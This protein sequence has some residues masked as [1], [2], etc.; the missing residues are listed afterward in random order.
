MAYFKLS[1]L[2][3]V[4]DLYN[5]NK[6]IKNVISEFYGNNKKEE[7]LKYENSSHSD[8]FVNETINMTDVYTKAYSYNEKL[9]LHQQG[10]KDLTF[11]LD[12]N[13]LDDDVWKEN[14]F[15]SKIKCGSQLL[16]E[17]KYNN[18]MLFT[19]K[20]VGY[21]ITE[22]NLTYSFTCQDSFSFTLSKQNDGYSISNDINSQNFIGA[23]NIDSWTNKIIE[24]CKISY[25]YI[26]LATPL[27]LFTDGTATTFLSDN[28]QVSKILKTGYVKNTENADLYETIPFSCSSTSAKG[29]LVSLG[30]QLGLSINTATILKNKEEGNF[31]ELVT[32][33]WYEMSKKDTVSGLKYSP[34]RN[35][36]SFN[37]SQNSDSLLT[38]LNINSR[39]LSSGEEVTPLS[40]VSPA[41]VTL[42]NSEYWKKFSIYQTGMYT[43]LLTG[44]YF[45]ANLDNYILKKV[46]GQPDD[47]EDDEI[48][49]NLSSS[50]FY[51]NITEEEFK[52]YSLYDKTIFEKD[53]ITCG[54]SAII[55]GE[56]RVFDATNTTIVQGFSQVNNQYLIKFQF[57]SIPHIV[58]IDLITNLQLYVY[59]QKD[60]TD[61]DEAFAKIADQ[62]PYL[63]N[64]L[65]DFNYFTKNNLISKTQDK[66]I[67]NI[68]YNDLRKV[69]SEIL[70][71]ANIYYNRIHKQ[72]E[73]LATMTNGIDNVGAELSRITDIYKE[74]GKVDNYDV[75]NIYTRWNL[76]QYNVSGAAQ[77]SQTDISGSYLTSG[78]ID[79]YKTTSDYMRKFLNARQRCLKNLYNFKNYFEEKLDDRYTHLYRVQIV[80]QD[81]NNPVNLYRFDATNTDTYNVLS[82][83][84][85]N[86]YKNFFSWENDKAAD[87]HNLL[88]YN[89]DNQHTIFDKDNYLITKTNYNNIRFHI[90]EDILK[91]ESYYSKYD[92]NIKYLREVCF[93]RAKTILELFNISAN[94][95]I[96]SFNLKISTNSG[97]TVNCKISLYDKDYNY[98]ICNKIFEDGQS[99]SHLYLLNG[100]TIV[101]EGI[102]YSSPEQEIENLIYVNKVLTNTDRELIQQDTINFVK[103]DTYGGLVF[104]QEINQYDI[105]KNYLWRNK[106]DLALYIKKDFTYK[107]LTELL[108]GNTVES[109][110]FY[111][112]KYPY[113]N[114]SNAHVGWGKYFNVEIYRM[115]KSLRNDDMIPT[116]MMVQQG[117]L[118]G[119]TAIL[120]FGSYSSTASKLNVDFDDDYNLFYS[121]EAKRN[122]LYI[123]NY[124]LNEYFIETGSEYKKHLIPTNTSYQN[125]Y[126]ITRNNDD[127]KVSSLANN[128][129]YCSLD[130]DGSIDGTGTGIVIARYFNHLFNGFVSEFPKS[131]FYSTEPIYSITGEDND[132]IAYTFGNLVNI[133]NT[134]P[135]SLASA[136]YKKTITYNQVVWGND[137]FNNHSNLNFLVI[138]KDRFL[139]DS[140][141]QIPSELNQYIYYDII[142]KSE[143]LTGREI[144]EKFWSK[145]DSIDDEYAFYLIINGHIQLID[146][147]ITEEEFYNAIIVDEYG[148]KQ[149]ASSLYD[150]TTDAVT[151]L[152]HVE[153]HVEIN[154]KS[155]NYNLYDHLLDN[156]YELYNDRGEK[157]YTINQLFGNLLYKEP[158]TYIYY[159]FDKTIPQDVRLHRYNDQSTTP[160]IIWYS[161]D[162]SGIEGSE[163]IQQY[164]YAPYS[165]FSYTVQVTEVE[166]GIDALE[167]TNGTFWYYFTLN[168]NIDLGE[169]KLIP[170]EYAAM[171]EST[172]QEYWNEAYASSLLCDIFIPEEWRIKQ[173]QVK[174]NFDVILYYV[175]DGGFNVELNTLYVPI[176]SKIKDKSY[177][178]TWDI[179]EP[180]QDNTDIYT[181]NQISLEQQAEVDNMI[182]YSQNVTTDCLFFTKLSDEASYYV[183]ER[184][185]CDWSTF[186]NN[187]AN[188]Y[189]PG[190]TGWNGVAINYLT[191][192]FVDYGKSKY[193]EL[194]EKRNNIWRQLYNKYPYLLLE[195]SYSNDSATT[196]E[197][198]LTMAKYDFEDKKYPEK[199][200]SISLIDLI[201][202]IE[203]VDDNGTYNPAFYHEPEL[204][205]GESIKVDADDYTDNVDDIYEALSQLLFITDIVRDLRNDGNCQ[206]TVNTIKYKDKLIRRLAKLIKKNPLK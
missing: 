80:V 61:E 83:S 93:I 140:N 43:D 44:A 118:F 47:L 135:S 106:D 139:I 101:V 30:E 145:R 190:Y 129:T 148:T 197:D 154:P 54:F 88:L 27:F 123:F 150:R 38:I 198:L 78:F 32:Y 143:V 92:K 171:I 24:D 191:S 45:T 112:L 6:Y 105:F 23:L 122:S 134:T 182:K 70:L 180:L 187:C 125:F 201:Q 82:E 89:N 189:L 183:I 130:S 120:T 52:K 73:Y 151:Y 205:I 65:I 167:L 55:E 168:E 53:K 35:I 153:E 75:N 91:Q 116:D 7:L 136:W 102:E 11:S 175:K 10:Q 172:L 79:L 67:K 104:Y 5:E 28:K 110:A 90:Y 18:L 29:A 188:I 164:G 13:I 138:K 186:L 117:P 4:Y 14:P 60:Y 17:D 16:L 194:L 97:G 21:T 20:N 195:G 31:I 137:Y 51:V 144:R 71:N 74:K 149:T 193:E 15:A 156:K 133:Y 162:V 62:L 152:Y 157:I 163:S 69:N 22:N 170:R 155:I 42:F 72:T 169:N 178:I 40:K 119:K 109:Y 181:Y 3:K 84:F 111:P 94:V 108:T 206:I 48:G 203:T 76:L 39:T 115:I 121:A 142:Q 33:F 124:P 99:F 132:K 174:N 2:T 161:F 8:S 56:E 57:P 41:F 100:S 46:V 141:E 166:L 63:E 176:V 12:K 9:S 202:D 147:N 81:E 58:E 114:I 26:N 192:H 177:S 107:P 85:A 19:V 50:T 160:D 64:K 103:D 173:E 200:Y 158:Q 146:N 59:F 113:A 37:L 1:L 131:F 34:F 95:Y 196:P 199:S 66:D 185:G 49:V 98:F 165:D 127:E 159:V 86:N 204:H 68:L 25:K 126:T 96:D 87:Y 77:S 179:R 184:G 128:G 36:N